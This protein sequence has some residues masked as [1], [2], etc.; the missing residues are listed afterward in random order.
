MSGNER[1]GLIVQ[2]RDRRLLDELA[3]MRVV[4]GEQAKIVAGFGSTSRANV[5]LLALVRAGLLRR[6]F[7]GTNAV[8]QKALYSLSKRGAE[9]VGSPMR[10]PRRSNGELIV[11]DFFIEHQLVTNE[12]YCTLKFGAL[13]SG[14]SFRQWLPFFHPLD[15][16][17][18]IPDGYVELATSRTMLS[19]F[20][21]V[22]LGH[23]SASVWKRKVTE[24]VNYALSDCHRRA[25]GP[26][27]F[28]VLV[29]T[30]S[31]RRMSSIMKT[32][33]TVTAK[34]FRFVTLAS[35]RAKGS[36]APIWYRVSPDG[37]EN[38]IPLIP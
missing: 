32:T 3:A 13:P 20:L 24:Y 15:R 7:L 14:V 26:A 30:S 5:R 11:A 4:T 6:F 38:P 17:Q 27:T 10:G 12:L 29:V 9:I 34:L 35:L 33:A 2:A 28:V 18:L 37:R 36:F 8:G 31:E 25:F 1:R 22:D 19:A 16:T 21:E 23:E